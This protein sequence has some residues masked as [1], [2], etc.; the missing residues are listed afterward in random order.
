MRKMTVRMVR[1]RPYPR[2]LRLAAWNSRLMVSRKPLVWRV[3]TQASTRSKCLRTILATSFIGS[4]FER[5]TLV[6][7][8]V[9]SLSTTLGCFR[10]RMS[11][12][13]SRYCQARAARLAVL[14]TRVH[15]KKAVAWPPR[16]ELPCT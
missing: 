8:C 1:N 4:T 15:R 3:S 12:S 16:S 9:R 14:S 11:R 5:M 6:H 7:H 2:A 13:C 10:E